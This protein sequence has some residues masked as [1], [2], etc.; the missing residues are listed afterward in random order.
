M[1]LT[2]EGVAGCVLAETVLLDLPLDAVARHG[3]DA[4]DEED[5]VE[6]VDLVLQDARA[7]A[8]RVERQRPAVHVL[9]LDLHPRGA[10]DRGERP[11][12]RQAS[13]LA[14]RLA[15]LLDD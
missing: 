11:R 6:V 1:I 12:D 8:T 4:I 15:A 13:L 5:A 10:R 3:V 9:R 2:R 7:Q 14:R